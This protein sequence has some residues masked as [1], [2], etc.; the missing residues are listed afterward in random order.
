MGVA[1]IQDRI[2]L[3]YTSSIWYKSANKLPRSI[4]RL[5][6][7]I[8]QL[9]TEFGHLSQPEAKESLRLRRGSNDILLELGHD[10]WPIGPRTREDCP[11]WLTF[12]PDDKYLSDLLW[13]NKKHQA[14]FVN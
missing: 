3:K 1:E 14:K 9:V 6:E 8:D 13:S 5:R 11:Q 7:A 4:R 2:G 12:A 10:I